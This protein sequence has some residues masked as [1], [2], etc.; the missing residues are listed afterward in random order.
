MNVTLRD[1][2][3]DMIDKGRQALR[4][5]IAV[6]L[7]APTGAG[8]TVLASF[9]ISQTAARGKSA[10]FICHR[11]EL[12]E[13]TSKTFH[14]YG[15]P[16]SIIA[17][18]YP[19]NLRQLVQ[20]CSIDTLKNRL[21][22]LTPPCIAIIDEAHHCTAAGWA[23]VIEWLKEHGCRIIGLSA[24]PKRLDGQGMD[25]HFDEMVLGPKVS[26]LMDEGHLSD[27]KMFCPPAPAE[28]RAKGRDDGRSAQA[29]VLDKPKLVGDVV[30]HWR[31]HAAG[32]RTV[33]FACNVAHSLHMVDA[34]KL[35]G[36]PAAHLDGGTPKA[37]RRKI[38]SDFADG[39]ILVLW[40]VA[41]FGEGFD[42]AAIAQKDVTIDCVILNRK[43]MSVSL[44]LQMV[45]RALRP[46]L[47]K[48]AIILDH[49]DNLRAHGY[50]DDD[51]EWS[52]EGKEKGKGNSNSGPPPPVICEGCFNAVRRPLPP[53]CPHCGKRLVAEA[54]EMKVAEGELIEATRDSIK[55]QIRQDR[56]REE[57]EA[58]SIGELVALGRK[59]GYQ[60][61]QQWAQKKFGARAM[62]R[63]QL[64]AT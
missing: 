35:A 16:H 13:G 26:W 60:Y 29:K 51:R 24:T 9:M 41:L 39:K 31:Q 63:R 40:N 7:Q 6:L 45:G 20:V 12:V 36:I 38:I 10:W 47:G 27:Y 43:T 3:A 50:P 25:A 34:F 18:G 19:M 46:Y 14:K 11:A 1:Y 21:E 52:L 57:R 48:I 53:A 32:L 5:A 55:R 62:K 15:Q 64:T 37:E 59:R 8:K 22:Y 28:L 42:L 49:A 2:Q 58:E 4:C 23:L 56:A 33:G 30:Q 17:A 61:P 44:Y 54:K